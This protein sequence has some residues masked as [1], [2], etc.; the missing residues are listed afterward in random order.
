MGRRHLAVT[1]DEGVEDAFAV[2]GVILVA[3]LG[4][5]GHLLPAGRAARIFS[6]LLPCRM[7]SD[8][9]KRD[10]Q[11]PE[12]RLQARS[13]VTA[14]GQR[15]LLWKRPIVG[16]AGQVPIGT[17]IRRTV[18]PSIRDRSDSRLGLPGGGHCRI[19]GTAF[20]GTR[21]AK[22][23]ECI[24]WTHRPP[25]LDG[26]SSSAQIQHN[27]EKSRHETRA[28]YKPPAGHADGLP[29]E[30]R[31]GDSNPRSPFGDTAFPVLHNRPL[32]HLSEI[33]AHEASARLLGRGDAMPRFGTGL[34]LK[35]CQGYRVA[36]NR[37]VG[38]MARGYMQLLRHPCYLFLTGLASAGELFGL[39]ALDVLVEGR[40]FV[41]AAQPFIQSVALGSEV[42]PFGI[43]TACFFGHA[44]CVQRFHPF[45]Q[46]LFGQL[47]LGFQ[48][49]SI[50]GQ[51]HRLVLQILRVGD[52]TAKFYAIRLAPRK[53]RRHNR[54]A[55]WYSVKAENSS[56][57]AVRPV[58]TGGRIATG[59][60]KSNCDKALLSGRQI[61]SPP[62][63]P[64]L[65]HARPNSAIYARPNFRESSGISCSAAGGN[66]TIPAKI[67][68]W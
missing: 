4:D 6:I 18:Q 5:K 39:A 9:R 43:A 21:V 44:F 14:Q 38:K 61:S 57:K 41:D 24:G 55:N 10:R 56:F 13:P 12:C 1:T 59:T 47:Q 15:I 54:K 32:C 2:L 20:P 52:F 48:I 25:R 16:S 60:Q 17:P 31:G 26:E 46:C 51:T 50:G 27:N 29:V 19:L 30:R 40:D 22:T 37:S 65:L 3:Q 35:S 45:I 58:H 49:A 53:N 64:R 62:S 63:Q 28:K 68:G 67:A 7:P 66:W 11:A 36:F 34:G 23:A 42:P 33:V 8:L